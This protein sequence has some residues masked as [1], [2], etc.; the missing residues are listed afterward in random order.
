MANVDL[1]EIMQQL[2]QVKSHLFV[3]ILSILISFLTEDQGRF[4]VKEKAVSKED[5]V[6]KWG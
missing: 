3:W 2:L 4:Q 6:V 5:E 1:Q